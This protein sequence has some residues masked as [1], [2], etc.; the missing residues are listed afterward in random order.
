MPTLKPPRI[1]K[2]GVG[3]PSN[4]PKVERGRP[5]AI[6]PEIENALLQ[7]LRDGQSVEDACV[8]AGISRTSYQKYLA[9]GKEEETGYFAELAQRIYRAKAE[10]RKGLVDKLVKHEGLR[11]AD[12]IAI[13]ER[14]DR[15]NW[16]PPKQSLEVEGELRGSNTTVINIVSAVPRIEKPTERPLTLEDRRLKM[17]GAGEEKVG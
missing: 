8:L 12:Y 15:Q 17:L 3:R 10:F 16:A 6:T 13:L 11:P 7:H 4:I 5:L 14:Q 1:K 9:K 2:A